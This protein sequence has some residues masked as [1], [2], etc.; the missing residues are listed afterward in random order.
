ME[1][2]LAQNHSAMTHLPIAASILTAAAAI[3]ALIVPRKEVTLFWAVLSMVALLSAFPT[4]VTG[5]AAGK[6]RTNDSGRP[7][8]E[9]GVFVDHSPE[10][11]RVYRHQMLAISGTVI[12]A[13]LSAIAI[14]A[15]RGRKPNPYLVTVLSLL[16]I[17]VWGIGGHLGGKELWGPDTFPALRP[18]KQSLVS[19]ERVARP[20]PLP[21]QWR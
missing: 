7:Y 8:I 9:R 5:I 6:G 1:L 16:M 12:A 2:F 21:G 3:V 10:N 11:T 18:G 13:V 4:I 14:T 19:P 17:L 15:L 20:R